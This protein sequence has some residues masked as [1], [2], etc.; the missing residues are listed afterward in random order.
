MRSKGAL[1]LMEQL[2][3]VLVFALAAAL[4]L[5]AFVLSDRMSRDSQRRTRALGEAQSMAEVYKNCHGDAQQAVL[6]GG[7]QVVRDGWVTLWDGD[8]NP[9]DSGEDAVYQV[10]VLPAPSRQAGLG[11]AEV[12]AMDAATEGGEPLCA[13]SIAYQ[14][15]VAAHG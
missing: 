8:W 1:V 13:F 5:Q 7:G 9:A 2:V 11:R 10:R 3:M 12:T 14:T 15:E 6:R 4:C